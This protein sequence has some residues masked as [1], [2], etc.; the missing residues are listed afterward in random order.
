MFKWLQ[1][2]NS[3]ITRKIKVKIGRFRTPIIRGIVVKPSGNF[4][5]LQQSEIYVSLC[6]S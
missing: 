5:K 1:N 3:D 4:D 2:T 6:V